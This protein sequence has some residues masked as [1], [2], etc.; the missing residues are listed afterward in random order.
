MSDS[1][2]EVLGLPQE[3]G[4]FTDGVVRMA[5]P[6][7]MLDFPTFMTHLGQVSISELWKNMIFDHSIN[8]LRYMMEKTFTGD[9]VESVMENINARNYPVV[10]KTMIDMN[11]I[12]LEPIDDDQKNVVE[13]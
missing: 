5:H 12:K 11:G 3:C 6:I 10:M 2:S 13:V 9:S 8:A 7:S 1:L 4:N